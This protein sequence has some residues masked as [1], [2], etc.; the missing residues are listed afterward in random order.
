MH[1]HGQHHPKGYEVT[2]RLCPARS[3]L[4]TLLRRLCRGGASLC[5]ILNRSCIV[6]PA[7]PDKGILSCPPA[8]AG[9]PVATS[10]FIP[11]GDA[12]AVSRLKA[13]RFLSVNKAAL[14][15]R[16]GFSP[17]LVEDEEPSVGGKTSGGVVLT[18][19]KRFWVSCELPSP[20]R[21]FQHAGHSSDKLPG[22]CHR[23]N[24]HPHV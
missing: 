13:G 21:V 17:V 3:P 16:S 14:G 2:L 9:R 12:A 11:T 18:H 4:P 7:A 6:L 19:P 8:P 20:P 10:R 1:A 5:P 15:N 23:A 22:D 24:E